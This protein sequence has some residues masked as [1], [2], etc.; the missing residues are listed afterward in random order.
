MYENLS[1]QTLLSSTQSM[2]NLFSSTTQQTDQTPPN[3]NRIL[4][5][6]AI[7]SLLFLILIIFIIAILIKLHRFRITSSTEDK[8]SSS[9][10]APSTITAISSD[11]PSEIYQFKPDKPIISRLYDIPGLV[12]HTNLSPRFHRSYHRGYDERRRI[13]LHIQ[14]PTL[15]RI[16]PFIDHGLLTIDKHANTKRRTNLPRVTR[17]QNGDVIISA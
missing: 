1:N 3:F 16:N 12:P 9:S 8:V 4:I 11:F 2:F 7:A 15:A 10:F 17:L 14:S 5:I 6:I 13:P